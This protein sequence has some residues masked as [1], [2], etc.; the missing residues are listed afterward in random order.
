MFSKGANGLCDALGVTPANMDGRDSVS[1]TRCTFS[2]CA[3]SIGI[4]RGTIGPAMHEEGGGTQGVSFVDLEDC[5]SGVAGRNISLVDSNGGR[6]QADGWGSIPGKYKE[7]TVL[8]PSLV[9]TV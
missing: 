6:G 2:R 5:C 4:D 9:P 8:R 1:L 7:S 3:A